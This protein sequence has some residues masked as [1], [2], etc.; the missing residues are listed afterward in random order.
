MHKRTKIVCTVGPST[1]KPEI[2]DAMIA[3]GMNVARFNFSHGTHADHEKR[4]A[5]VR[6]AASKAGRH[7][8]LMLDTKGPEMRLGKFAEGKVQLSTGQTFILTGREVSG[9]QEIAA[10]NYENLARE[11]APGM[12]VLLADGLIELLIERIEQDDI[13]TR[14]LNSGEVSN[15]K[16]VAV[17]GACINLPPVSEQDAADIRFGIEQEMDLIAASFIQQAANVLA[18]RRILED[19]RTHMEIIAKIENTPGVSN[20]D[21]I[22]KVA[23]GIM[24]ARGDL[25]VEIP[26]ED[27]PLVQKLLIKKCNEAGKPVITATQML[28]SMITN[29]RPTRAE[30]SDVANAIL[31]G[32]DAIMLSGETASGRYPVEAVAT[33]AKIAL[34]TEYDLQYGQLLLRSGMNAISTTTAA[35]SHASA[36]IAY[37]LGA[38]AIITATETGYTARM[39]SQHRPETP[40]IAV[41]PSA[42]T[43]RQMQL[44]WGVFPV[45]D[46]ITPNHDDRM[47]GSIN[48][49]LAAKMIEEGDLVVVTAGISPG[50]QGTTNMIQVHIVAEVLLRGQ[51]AGNA[52]YTG[53]ACVVKSAA[54][55]AEKF[56]AGNVLIVAD[57]DESIA[58]YAVK[59]GA[60]IAEEGGLSS[61]AAIIGVTYD[62]PV[63]VNAVGAT[64]QLNDGM[65][66]TVDAVRG[67]VFKGETNAR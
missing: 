55:I 38:A 30:A 60:I 47:K 1:D 4:I 33:M 22:L 14:V 56:Q 61:N 20:I 49:A 2:L 36:Q 32:T 12:K 8:A 11:V 7:I 25:G 62:I 16:R 52:A 9:T 23:D 15:N 17:P 54:E 41:T 6:A 40:I 27:V 5:L 63:I 44:L 65:L 43:A 13:I 31:D 51:G 18:I 21:D 66:V 45:V 50:V 26:P 3:A 57:V 35:I 39:V 28:E 19:A 46:K 67:L 59:A 58:A 64:A 24:V 29:P 37:E 10:V 53:T 34:R 42:K 48:A